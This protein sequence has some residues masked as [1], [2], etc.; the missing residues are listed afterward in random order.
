[1]QAFGLRLAQALGRGIAGHV[2]RVEGSDIIVGWAADLSAPN[3]HLVVECVHDGRVV[4]TATADLPRE[5][6]RARGIG[7][8]A[9]G[10]RFAPPPDAFHGEA[11]VDVRV[12]DTRRYLTPRA[13][14]LRSD[15]YIWFVA[16]DVVNNCNLRCPFCLVDYSG[17]TKTQVMSDE[18]F[19][20]LV[21][22]LPAVADGQFYLSCL[23]E[24]T[25]HPR[26]NGLLAR[27]PEAHRRKVFFTTNLARPLKQAD[28]EAWAQSGLRHINVSLDTLD[29]ERF[30]VLRRHG[31]L[32]VFLANLDAMT[33][34]F[35]QTP[36][37]P[38]L[39]YITM[40]FKSNVHEIAG[41]VRTSRERW[42]STEN[43]IRY[44][45]NVAH[46][47]DDFRRR[48][49]LE[50]DDWAALTAALEATG[51]PIAIKYPPEDGY[52]ELIPPQNF[53]EPARRPGF[54]PRIALT[55][56]MGLRASADGTV[57]VSDAEDAFRININSLDDPP[58]F[59]RAI[60]GQARLR[61][62]GSILAV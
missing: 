35:R 18:T 36:G 59:F 12:R 4:A 16:A 2:D 42:L 19:E 10:F 58:A 9:H 53:F 51:A 44:T 45:F 50:R 43:E 55:R 20:K 52:E 47:T 15:L 3:K 30:A 14:P 6:L 46:I 26:L 48:E 11:V 39:R 37:A 32:D 25:L 17:V 56:P 49:Y 41:I 38:A 7:D 54:A 5:D 31:R 8:G 24:P 34:V 27:I 22:L 62:D 61:D 28:F 21:S 13:L 57:L 33:A 1:M 60:V 40:A 23:H 29:A